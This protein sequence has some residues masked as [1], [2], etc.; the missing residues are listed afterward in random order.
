MTGNFTG[1]C[2]AEFVGTFLIVFVGCGACIAHHSFAPDINHLAVAVAFGGVV[3]AMVYALGHISGAHF[4]PAVTLAFALA[5]RFPAGRIVPYVI[6]QCLGAVA[7]SV[8]HIAAYGWWMAREVSFA[9]TVPAGGSIV[10]AL[11]MEAALTFLLMF[12]IVAVA[13]DRRVPQGVS[14]VA[15]GMAVCIGCIA[16]GKCCGASMNPARSLGPALLAGGKALDVLWMYVAGPVA[17]AT[18]AALVY[19]RIRGPEDRVKSVPD[20][21][22]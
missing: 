10:H 6:S 14:G 22:V 21:G 4:N 8:A 7:G 5:G 20:F 16:G 18:I 17:G 9:A 2:V 11:A 3:M 15:I 12:V 13:S 19:E 1:K